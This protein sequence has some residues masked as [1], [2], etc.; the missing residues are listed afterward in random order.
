MN[1]CLGVRHWEHVSPIAMGDVR[2]DP[3]ADIEVGLTRLDSTPD[4]WDQ[5][6]FDGGETSLSR[7]VRARAAGDDRVIG[8]PVFLMTA[9]RHRCI[10]VRADSAAE[11]PAHLRGGRI[12]LTGWPDSGNTWT[13]AIFAEAGVGVPDAQWRVGRL[14]AAHPAFDR[15]GGV[16]VPD[17]V[18][19]IEDA[20]TLV[21][22]LADGSLDAV[23]T[24]F[25]PPGFYDGS[26][27]LRPLYRDTRAAEVEYYERHRFVPGIHLLAVRRELFERDPDVPQRLLDLFEESKRVSRARRDKLTDVSPWH[28][29]EVAA[30][31]QVFDGDWMPYGYSANERMVSEFQDALVAQGL[32]DRQVP[33]SDLF[34]L[35]LEPRQSTIERA[36]A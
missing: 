30:T 6:D 34:P 28:N 9:F 1:L 18:D 5:D 31:S 24:P 11:H 27:G 20:D 16:S 8:L 3:G 29:E 23:L 32:L 12:G 10:I 17:N 35:A 7:Y 15:I 13:R 25:M 22:L 14:T 36:Y 33:P 19:Q 2:P 21:G 4:L 26:A